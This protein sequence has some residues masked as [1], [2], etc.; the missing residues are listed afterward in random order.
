LLAASKVL[1][2]SLSCADIPDEAR[3]TVPAF[4]DVFSERD[5]H[6]KLL[7]IFAQ[8]SELGSLPVDMSLAGSQV[9]FESILVQ[10]PHV[11]WH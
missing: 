9:A 4:C 11:L 3:K 7:S 6:R 1:F 2:H 10:L 5:F 8:A